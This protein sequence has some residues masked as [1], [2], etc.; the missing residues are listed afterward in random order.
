MR[1]VLLL[2]VVLAASPALADKNQEK[3]DQY[4]AEGRELLTKKQDAKGACEKF[5]LAIQLDPT[6]P[7]VMLNL[8]LCYEMQG[9]FATSLYWFRKAQFAAAEAKGTDPG[10]EQEAK[11]HTKDLATKVAIAR[12]VDVPPAARISVDGRPVR[13]EDYSRLEVDRDS[14]IEARAPGKQVFRQVVQVEGQ[15][16]KDI[17]IQMKDEVTP[18]MRDP[19][20][21]RRRLAYVVGAGGVVLWGITLAYG[22]A[23]R[24]RYETEGGAYSGPNGYDEAKDDLRFKGTG[25]FI[26]GTLA[27]GAAI[28][29]YVTAPKPYRERMEQAHVVPLVTPDSAGLGFAT[30]F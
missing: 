8:G 4:F 24:D 2:A 19:G 30:S 20:K 17:N 5:E 23:V 13:T 21:G 26:G 1:A 9:K 7:G 25:L 18:P 27:V 10:Y 3:A 14:T 12:I 16:A 15:A 6:A 11:A 29:L 28:V 22:L